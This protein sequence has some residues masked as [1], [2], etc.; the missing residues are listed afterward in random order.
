MESDPFWFIG[1]PITMKSKFNPLLLI[2]F[3]L[4]FVL[5]GTMY[6]KK[7]KEK[8]DEDNQWKIQAAFQELHLVFPTY[9]KLKQSPKPKEPD[10][11]T[12]I[13]TMNTALDRAKPTR[14]EKNEN[15]AQSIPYEPMRYR[16]DKPD[17]QWQMVL[18]YEKE[19]RKVKAEA[20]GTDISVPV[21]M[22]EYPCCHW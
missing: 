4:L 14:L 18:T 17:A 10:L 6:L 22:R 5:I 19:T 15:G 7:I 12:I 2:A 8:G 9:F 13:E 11:P 20:Y 16:I 3:F 1:S 21:S